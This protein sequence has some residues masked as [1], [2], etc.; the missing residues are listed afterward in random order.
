VPHLVGLAV[1]DADTLFGDSRGHQRDFTDI[2]DISPSAP[3]PESRIETDAIELKARLRAA[4]RELGFFALGVC[5]A[6]P[7]PHLEF[8]R[9]WLSEGR[10]GTMTYL[11]RQAQLRSDPRNLLSS[12]RSVIMVAL[13]YYRPSASEP[14][15]PRFARYALGRDYHKV[16]RGRL[17]KLARLLE[18][19]VPGCETRTCVDS[20]PLFE[21]DYAQLAGIG[22]F[23]KNTCLIDSRRGSWFLLGA[24]LSS[25]RLQPDEPAIGGCG[26][27]TRCIDACPTGAIVFDRDR[28]QI[29][30]RRCISYLTI[31]HRGEIEPEL[32][33]M[34]GEWT[35]GC[36][37]C[38]EV[39]PFNE[40]R[41]HQP[42]RVEVTR[43]PDV[44][45]T[46]PW[47]S[48]VE[49]AKVSLGDWDLL[50]Q[51]SAIRRA[52]HEGLRRNANINLSS[53]TGLR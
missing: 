41:E 14:G 23:G 25:Y 43:D 44:L 13:N 46:R 39:C 3:W 30:S 51:G 37:V 19:E 9:D 27:C 11:D 50:T 1:A 20:A 2:V 26:T 6:R 33:A 29:D 53:G 45:Q 4:A 38:Q 10:H 5:D 40:P 52:G 17:R 42:L 24:L 8:Y 47:P 35:F 15:Q 32:G 7:A 34:V 31:E 18:Q 21:R 28:W 49:L 22:W 16:F 36:D 12:C 48:L